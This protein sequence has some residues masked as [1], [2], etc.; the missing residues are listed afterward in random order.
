MPLSCSEVYAWMFNN[1]FHAVWIRENCVVTT[2]DD[3]CGNC[4]RHCPAGA[5][6]MV[7]AGFGS[8]HKVPAIDT[9]RCIGCGAC[10]YHCPARPHSAIYVVG[11]EVHS[12]I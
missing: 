5:I 6:R 3:S 8:N 7:P 12:E 2:N 9:A 10:E 11:H 1:D 4:A